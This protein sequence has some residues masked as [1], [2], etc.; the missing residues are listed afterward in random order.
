MMIILMKIKI[1]IVVVIIIM[2]KMTMMIKIILIIVIV[3]VIKIN[4]NLFQR[5]NLSTTVLNI[6]KQ[7][8]E[9]VAIWFRHD[10]I[11]MII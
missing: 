11:G 2:P 5:G 6:L 7:E 3:I 1:I 10:M 4:N 8:S 9:L